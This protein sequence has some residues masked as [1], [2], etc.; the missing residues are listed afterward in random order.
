MVG[1]VL[2]ALT[3][4]LSN[5]LTRRSG[6]GLLSGA[7]VLSPGLSQI[8]NAR[9]KKKKKIALC[10]NGQTV[11][12]PK[13]K[14][15]KFLNQGAGTGPCINGCGRDQKPC[16][17]ICIPD[18][19]CCVNTDCPVD[20]VCENGACATPRCGN[21]GACT[22]F[23][24][25]AGFS[26]TQINGLDGGDTRCQ[27]AADAANL[28]GTF[29]AWLAVGSA[30]PATRFTNINKSGPYHLVANGSDG[31]NPPPLVAENFADLL[32]CGGG[33]CLSNT[34]NRVENGDSPGDAPGV[35][36]GVLADGAASSDTC[37]EWNND[38]GTGLV[39]D[40]SSATTNWTN[41][42]FAAP[43]GLFNRLYCFQQAS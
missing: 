32:T 29:K 37:G 23:R 28:A 41:S 13:K 9:K 35:W 1:S 33:V 14:A 38:A 16:D 20:S 10:F 26:A 31:G 27:A 8:A 2:D 19:N 34:I 24:T 39:G 15:K 5:R 22:V 43:C 17:G 21:G 42:Q 30:T 36:T 3:R 12:T 40:P 25:L 4:C 11:K 18:T 6:M 7:S